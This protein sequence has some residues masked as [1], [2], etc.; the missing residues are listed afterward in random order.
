MG[1]NP[2]T[3]VLWAKTFFPFSESRQT[4]TS[5]AAGNLQATGLL[6]APGMLSVVWAPNC[7]TAHYSCA[8]GC[9][10]QKP[11]QVAVIGPA[12]WIWG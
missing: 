11:H 7:A 4:G 8:E 5:T 2:H 3:A 6:E 10:R 12:G 1:L 9:D